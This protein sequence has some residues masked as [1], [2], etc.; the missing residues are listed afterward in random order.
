MSFEVM[1]GRHSR[2]DYLAHVHS[3]ANP[4]AIRIAAW[5]LATRYGDGGLAS[6][7]LE[8]LITSD[9][10]NSETYAADLDFLRSSGTEAHAEH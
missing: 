1:S 5:T 9:S 6:T 8:Q 2:S 10:E 7:L 3:L 4:A